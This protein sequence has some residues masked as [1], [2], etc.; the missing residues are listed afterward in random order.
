MTAEFIECTAARAKSLSPDPAIVF[1]R[2]LVED[3]T[4]DE[5]KQLTDDRL[6]RIGTLAVVGLRALPFPEMH[7]TDTMAPAA[8]AS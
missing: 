4:D 5:L 1:V 3:R 8:S 2:H 6:S 7:R